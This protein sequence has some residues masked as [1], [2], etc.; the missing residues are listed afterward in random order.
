MVTGEDFGMTWIELAFQDLIDTDATNPF[1]IDFT[2]SALDVNGNPELDAFFSYI[3]DPNGENKFAFEALNGELITNL[4]YQLF[5]GDAGGIRQVRIASEQAGVPAV[6][7]ASTWALMML[8]FGAA[9][10]AM[11]RRR[12]EWMT[13]AQIA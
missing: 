12:G 1:R 11:R 3:L 10:F 6:P 4:S 13:L 2:L 8:G 9:G 5:G 7:E